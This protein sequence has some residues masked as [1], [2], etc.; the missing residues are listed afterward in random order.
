MRMLGLAWRFKAAAAK[1]LVLQLVL[2]AMALSGLGLL[3]L[4]IDVLKHAVQADSAEPSWPLGLAPPDA[5]SAMA[6]VGLVAGAIFLIAAMRFFLDRWST[7]Q[8]A[9]FVH[10]IVADLRM[11]VYDKLQ[12][13]SFQFFD[14][15]D[16]GSIINRVT[17]D[18]Q[19]V[20][21]F[22]ELAMI[23]I[24]MIVV[25]IA[26][27]LTYMGSIHMQLTLVCLATSPLLLIMTIWF[28][29]VVKPA[30]RKNRE[31]FDTT[32]RVLSENVRGHHVVKGFSLENSEIAKFHATNGEFRDQQQWIFW[33]VSI[34][35]PAIQ[36]IPQINLIV[37]LTYG[38]YLYMQGE[39]L[40]GSGLVVFASLLQQ[41]SNQISQ[42]AQITNVVQRSIVSA[43][44][45]FEV[46][47]APL[48][49]DT[50]PD[51]KPMVQSR[52]E[53]R[54]EGVEFRYKPD[55][56]P[57]L[58]DISFTAKPGQTVAILGA[59]GAGKTSLLSLIPRFYDPSAGRVLIDGVDV[60][61]LDVQDLRRHIGIV[62]QE[63]F[64]FSTTVAD[65]IAFGHPNAS[66]D[67]IENAAK[68][69]QAHEFIMELPDG[70][71]TVLSESGANLSGGQ[72][73]RL[74]IARAVLLE[75]PIL[76]LDDPTAA[77]DPETEG[78]ILEAMDRAMQGRTTLVVA[79][80]LSTLRR[81]DQVLVLDRGTLAQTGTH[82]Q[83]MSEQGHY[84]HAAKL[85]IA[86]DESLRLLGIPE[87]TEDR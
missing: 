57:V 46:L 39:I 36:M 31:L 9:M 15:N 43:D 63:S 69:A 52:G 55:S 2:L 42:V 35:V 41:F 17:G 76:L 64:L 10:M 28:G 25:S 13:L 86:D 34:F 8:L 65:N 84:Q 16:S 45:V 67:Q 62:F 85:Q 29:N 20:R 33:R 79:H 50:S 11:M 1:V 71:N 7:I 68:I 14:A 18:V 73:Q 19:A 26:F 82:T 4:G 38:G 40:F 44:R 27:F 81:A 22:I 6:K 72:R 87:H 23:Q 70:Y 21:M 61:D 80:R 77:I 74:A 59:T 56:D 51:A 58:R 53:V 60:R 3:G 75:P 47:D 24:V 83:L 78:E 54:F 30:Y 12:Q 5:W 49:I 32:V 37:L 48:A 66:R